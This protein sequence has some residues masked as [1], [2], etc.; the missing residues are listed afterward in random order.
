M[1]KILTSMLVCMMTLSL[2]LSNLFAL[3]SDSIKKSYDLVKSYYIKQETLEVDDVISYESLGLES[4]DL[5]MKEE[6]IHISDVGGLSKAIIALTLHGEDPRHYKGNNLVE[7]LE[8]T[9][10]KEGAAYSGKY[11]SEANLQVYVVLALFVVD[12]DK[13][14]IATEYLKGLIQTDGSFGYTDWDGSFNHDPQTTGWAIEAF[15]LVNKTQ[16]QDVISQAISF[17]KSVQDD[18]GNYTSTYSSGDP[19]T[20]AVP[21]M[22]LLTYDKEGLKAGNY[23]KNGNN[24]LEYI[25]R[26]QNKDGSFYYPG[27]PS[28]GPT[29]GEGNNN[30]LATQQA[31]Q[32][33]GYYMNG[34]I[35]TKA[36]NQYLQLPNSIELDVTEKTLMQG[37]SLKL[38]AKVD[39][40]NYST[41]IWSVDDKNIVSVD[42]YG[43]VVA[44]KAGKTV[45]RVKTKSGLEAICRITVQSKNVVKED[46]ENKT[47]NQNKTESPQTKIPTQKANIVETDDNNN[48]IAFTIL[49]MISIGLF[50]GLRKKNEKSYQ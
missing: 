19:N 9:I 34:N 1:K 41:F 30:P 11:A 36:R 10:G 42:N 23:D 47:N 6:S 26:Y 48:I 20:Q 33:L 16:Y 43:K 32:V 2:S 15:T 18:E 35:Y 25:L 14:Q 38:N 7:K 8:E 44:L 49:A 46:N 40:E 29:F 37:D 31:A 22:G 50:I 12:S 13:T 39:L 45:V 24:P 27:D 3:D 5:E 21:L 28:W 4:E 17:L